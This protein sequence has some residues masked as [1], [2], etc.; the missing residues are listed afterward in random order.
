V[1]HHLSQEGLSI[2]ADLD[3]GEHVRLSSSVGSAAGRVAAVAFIHKS[4]LHFVGGMN[5]TGGQTGTALVELWRLDI[6]GL[7]K[8]RGPGLERRE[9]R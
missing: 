5:V 6:S 7:S 3:G 1:C 8:M 2:H 9:T 4:A